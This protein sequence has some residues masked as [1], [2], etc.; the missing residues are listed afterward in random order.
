MSW[1]QLYIINLKIHIQK[2]CKHM[3]S[4]EDQ[5]SKES[6]SPSSGDFV[7]FCRKLVN[8]SGEYLGVC[9]FH[10]LPKSPHYPLDMR[11][12][13]ISINS[14]RLD[15]P[16]SL[17]APKVVPLWPEKQWVAIFK[18]PERWCMSRKVFLHEVLTCIRW[19]RLCKVLLEDHIAV[20]CKH[21]SLVNWQTPRLFSLQNIVIH[22]PRK[23]DARFHDMNYSA[24]FF[25]LNL[26]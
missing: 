5:N 25:I 16:Q 20:F 14:L 9:E 11:R 1:S 12:P 22:F 4:S 10:L 7:D 24:G 2:I 21:F 26:F 13:L 6:F 17:D 18:A 8:K 3:D 15:G 23:W 19:M